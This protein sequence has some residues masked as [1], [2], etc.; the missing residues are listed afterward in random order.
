MTA[1]QFTIAYC[2]LQPIDDNHTLSCY[3]NDTA[4]AKGNI[5]SSDELFQLPNNF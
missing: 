3:Y 2:L 1:D 4:K 5:A